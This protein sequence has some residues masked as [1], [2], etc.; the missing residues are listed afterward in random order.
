MINPKAAIHDF[1][2]RMLQT[3][4]FRKIRFR[5]HRISVYQLCGKTKRS[6]VDLSI[7]VATSEKRAYLISKIAFAGVVEP[8]FVGKTS[9]LNFGSILE[10]LE[11][12]VAFVYDNIIYSEYLRSKNFFIMPN[13]DFNLEISDS[14]ESI[15]QRMCR[16]KRKMM[17][18]IEKLG[19][20]CEISKDFEKLRF[21]YYDM[22]KSHLMEKYGKWAGAI[23]FDT[24]RRDFLNGG[25]LLARLNGKY[26]SGAVYRIIGNKLFVPLLG[27]CE[28]QDSAS[29][30][31]G[32]ALLHYLILLGK[33]K[34]C[35]RIDYEGAF[36]FF[37][38][39]L[40]NYKKTCGMEISSHKSWDTDIV[41]ARF[42]NFDDGVRDFVAEA[43]FIFEDGELKGL[44]VV[45]SKEN[46]QSTYNVPGL[47]SLVAL[48][49]KNDSCELKK[50]GAI[51]LNAEH[52]QDPGLCSLL[53]L[54]SQKN[55]EAYEL[56][57]KCNPHL[58]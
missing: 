14:W 32:L 48:C 35:T 31:A 17:R 41:A 5:A 13:I 51:P 7:V 50:Q 45:D 22:Y 20:E 36:P 9:L 33:S 28:S 44:A 1:S 54:A 19:Y 18:Q 16:T 2:W 55:Y 11:P 8:K 40:F 34:N 52:A 39:G 25:L 12:D 58:P 30:S 47:S 27:F 53:K 21:F 49:S 42:Q 6:G 46:L 57:L 4:L 38:Y 37:K 3:R 29:N 23:S 56:N 24:V 15:V 26:V 43:P 10:D